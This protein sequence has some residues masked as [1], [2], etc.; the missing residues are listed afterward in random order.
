MV[1]RNYRELVLVKE[2]LKQYIHIERLRIDGD[3]DVNTV[4]QLVAKMP[5]VDELQLIRFQGILSDVDLK[6]LEWVPSICSQRP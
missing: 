1:I 6:N 4:T 2:N 5:W 3:V